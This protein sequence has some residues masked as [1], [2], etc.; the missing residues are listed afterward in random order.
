MDECQS[1][2]VAAGCGVRGDLMRLD[3]FVSQALGVSRREA[4]GLIAGGAVEVSG[5]RVPRPADPV[6]PGHVITL[7]GQRLALPGPRYI[8]LYKPTG[9]LSATRDGSQQTVMSLLPAFPGAALHLAGRL[10]KDTSGL[11]LLSDDGAWTH[12]ITSPRH[13]CSK[14]YRAELAYPLAAD[15]GE[16]LAAGLLLRGETRPTR[17]ASI[18][19][20]DT[21]TVD[22]RVTEGRYHLVRRLFAA[23]G[24][25]VETLHRF[26]IG[27]LVLDPALRPGEWRELSHAER[28]SVVTGAQHDKA[29]GLES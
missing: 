26:R 2:G 16:R 14:Y 17:P 20:L 1:A 15:A 25:R 19:L 27:G 22:I 29:R 24:N 28:A 21:R 23:L 8:M 13:G 10:D 4:R 11:L 9:L 5:C 18:E 7:D 12:R 3:R 6:G